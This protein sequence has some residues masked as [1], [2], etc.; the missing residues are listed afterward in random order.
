MAYE[1]QT[2]TTGE[3]ITEE[4]LN[5]IEDGI[6]NA[7]DGVLV[8]NMNQTKDGDIDVFTLDKTW[9]EIFDACSTRGA[10]VKFMTASDYFLT[11]VEQLRGGSD[12]GLY[13]VIL[14]KEEF[15]T[16]SP[17]GYPTN[18]GSK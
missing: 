5:H 15:T 3:V 13:S 14:M 6:A 4:K 10:V 9:Q 17:N 11:S 12:Y 1:K 16:E 8:V 7:G 2:W 18:R